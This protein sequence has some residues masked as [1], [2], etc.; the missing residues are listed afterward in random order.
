MT[1]QANNVLANSAGKGLSLNKPRGNNSGKGL[2]SNILLASLGNSSTTLNSTK[3]N[4]FNISSKGLKKGEI[5][6][7]LKSTKPADPDITDAENATVLNGSSGIA[8]FTKQ[9]YSEVKKSIPVSSMAAIINHTKHSAQNHTLKIKNKT[10]ENS[11]N[12]GVGKNSSTKS[13]VKIKLT[14][15]SLGSNLNKNAQ[16]SDANINKTSNKASISAKSDSDLN[17]KETVDNKSSAAIASLK[18]SVIG[19]TNTS[20]SSA[21][22]KSTSIAATTVNNRSITINRSIGKSDTLSGNIISNSTAEKSLQARPDKINP[23][24][25]NNGNLTKSDN[26]AVNTKSSGISSLSNLQKSTEALKNN[27]SVQKNVSENTETKLNKP[28]DIIN[29]NISKITLNK[30][31]DRKYNQNSVNDAANSKN[32]ISR[33]NNINDNISKITLNK[34]QDRK[35]NQNSVNDAANSKNGI[36]RNNN[37]NGNISKITLDKKQ[38]RKYNQNSVIDAANSKNEKNNPASSAIND[39]NVEK[40]DNSATVLN[41][42]IADTAQSLKNNRNT[43]VKDSIVQTTVSI[44]PVVQQTDTKSVKKSAYISG[45][46]DYQAVEGSKDNIS[47]TQVSTKTDSGN[48]KKNQDSANEKLGANIIENISS[49]NL[50]NKVASAYNAA[51]NISSGTDSSASVQGNNTAARTILPN[52]ITSRT[53]T[54]AKNLNGDGTTSAKLQ[55]QPATL[56][57]INIDISIVNSTVKLVFKADTRETMQ[58]IENQAAGLKESF[59]KLGLKMESFDVKYESKDNY[60]ENNSNNQ[61][62]R[63]SNSNGRQQSTKQEY[64]NTLKAMSEQNLTDSINNYLQ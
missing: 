27:K 48:E 14:K 59:A 58:M 60:S 41:K 63:N 52:E 26:S 12:N 8:L 18:Q 28:A 49:R 19:S 15:P 33:N 16:S 56:G 21:G 46:Q 4:M 3:N 47:A 44:A 39:T 10:T 57:S 20:S 54:M 5:R 24:V 43:A 31:Q 30:K 7:Q 17:I 34:K 62:N 42:N 35:Y 50:A 22:E 38:D 45:S 32:G 51:A 40:K 6:L 25:S 55:L 61:F 11:D 13:D 64:L 29:D 53:L 23:L 36:S 37:I 9:K 1:M 2:F